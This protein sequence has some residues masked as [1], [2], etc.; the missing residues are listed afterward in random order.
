VNA[1]DTLAS[2]IL[3]V[4]GRVDLTLLDAVKEANPGIGDIDVIVPGLTMSFPSLDPATMVRPTRRGTYAVTVLTAPTRTAPE[5]ERVRRSLAGKPL[6]LE[7]LPVRLARD[8]EAVR[9]VVDGFDDP[10]EAEAFYRAMTSGR[11]DAP[12]PAGSRS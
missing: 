10:A 12:R 4:Y 7:L 3:R 9:V 6:A 11:L 2:L 8:L 5:V 1:G